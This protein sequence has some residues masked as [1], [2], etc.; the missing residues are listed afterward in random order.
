MLRS[1][2]L[3]QLMP[4]LSQSTFVASPFGAFHHVS[5]SR[6]RQ[7]PQLLLFFVSSVTIDPSSSETSA[8]GVFSGSVL[9]DARAALIR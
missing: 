3:R 2:Y 7:A 4:Q 6:V 1:A 5:D 8:A 9:P